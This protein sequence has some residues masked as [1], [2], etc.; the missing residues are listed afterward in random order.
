MPLMG[1]LD[2]EQVLRDAAAAIAVASE[3]GKVGIVG[4]C[5][6]GTVAWVAAARLP[7]LCAAVGYYG[8]SI[9]VDEGPR[10]EGPDDAAFR[11]EGPA[12]SDR[13]A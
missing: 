13:G 4:Y 1:K 12:H 11:R 9:L 6:G 2:F 7:G 5:F 8:G 10:A 3:G